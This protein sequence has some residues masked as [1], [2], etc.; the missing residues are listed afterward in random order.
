[1]PDVD[2]LQARVAQ[3][4]DELATFKAQARP[5]HVQE[6]SINRNWTAAWTCLAAAFLQ[7]LLHGG[8]MCLQAEA[9]AISAE[10]A[11]Q[12]SPRQDMRAQHTRMRWQ[13][14]V[15]GRWSVLCAG[16]GAAIY[17]TGGGARQGGGAV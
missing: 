9:A 11:G 10:Q 6:R 14:G 4:E 16:D 8:I 5:L 7:H 15:T 3:L 13:R 2:Q 1:M 12:V 17:S